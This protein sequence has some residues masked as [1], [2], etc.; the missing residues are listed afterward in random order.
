MHAKHGKLFRKKAKKKNHFTLLL[1]QAL[2]KF[3]IMHFWLQYW[4]DLA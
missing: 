2:L 4:L 1:L 3:F